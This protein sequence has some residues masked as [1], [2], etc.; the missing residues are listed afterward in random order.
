MVVVAVDP[1]RIPER[2]VVAEILVTALIIPT[3]IP[4]TMREN[5]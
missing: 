3:V 5:S 2:P 4:M 1:Q